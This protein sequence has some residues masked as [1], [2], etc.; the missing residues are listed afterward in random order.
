M[1]VKM[2]H[3]IGDITISKILGGDALVI[4]LSKKNVNKQKKEV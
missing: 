1:Y 2:T 3:E 4:I